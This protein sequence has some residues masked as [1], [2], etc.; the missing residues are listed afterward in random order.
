MKELNLDNIRILIH[1]AIRIEG[2]KV[3]YF[4]P[5]HLTEE[6]HDA[7][8]VFVTHDH[9]DHFLRRTSGSLPMRERSSWRL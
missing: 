7:D 4:D 5:Y 3:L 9:Y 2:S 6:P 1:S 8:V